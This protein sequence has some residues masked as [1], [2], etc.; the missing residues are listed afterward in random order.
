MTDG[1]VKRGVDDDRTERVGH[2]MPGDDL[3]GRHAGRARRE[4]ELLVLQRNHLPAD[5]ARH[6]QPR[7]RAERDEEQH[8]LAERR[9]AAEERQQD[10]D[11]HHV[12]DGVEHVDDPHHDFVDAAAEVAGRRAER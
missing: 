12:G 4:N 9:L 10:D 2:Q 5:D 11:D 3:P 1:I 6:R 8:E 7:H